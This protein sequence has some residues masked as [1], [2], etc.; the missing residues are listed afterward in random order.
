MTLTPKEQTRLQVLNSPL[1]EC[2]TLDLAAVQIGVSALAHGHRGRKRPNAD[3]RGC[4]G[5]CGSSGPH[6]VRRGHHN[7]LSEREGIGR[8]TL[9]RILV[10]PGLSSP[11]RR[12]APKHRVRRPSLPSRGRLIQ[13]DGSHHSWLGTRLREGGRPQLLPADPGSLA[14]PRPTYGP[15]HRPARSLQA[16]TRI[17]PHWDADPVQPGHVGTGD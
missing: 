11:R 8:A 17:R 6:Q 1:A 10:N 9:R 2:M 16:H 14:D 13:M 15:L 12:H 5:R 7:H 3:T 4:D